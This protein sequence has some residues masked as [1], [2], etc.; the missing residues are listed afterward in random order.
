[1]TPQQESFALARIAGLERRVSQLE[2]LTLLLEADNKA[3][4]L[5]KEALQSEILGLTQ[6]LKAA[7]L[8]RYA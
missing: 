4:K 7:N 2:K 3:I 8:Y 6:D 1:M 5:D